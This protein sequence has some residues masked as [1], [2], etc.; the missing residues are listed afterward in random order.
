MPTTK[1]STFHDKDLK[2]TWKYFKQDLQVTCKGTVVYNST[3]GFVH[4]QLAPH[5]VDWITAHYQKAKYEYVF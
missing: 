2:L 1:T 5:Q 3:T 4:P